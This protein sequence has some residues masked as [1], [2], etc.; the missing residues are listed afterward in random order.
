MYASLD[1]ITQAIDRLNLTHMAAYDGDGHTIDTAQTNTDTEL[2]D[3]VTELVNNHSGTIRLECWQAPP[4]RQ[5]G[6]RKADVPKVER[7]SWRVRGLLGSAVPPVATPERSEP[8][9]PAPA[10]PSLHQDVDRAIA[11][12]R[13]EWE[14]ERLKIEVKEL[15][16]LDDDDDD[17]DDREPERAAPALP[18]KLFGMTG[19]QTFQILQGL[20]NL[21]GRNGQQTIAGTGA[22]NGQPQLTAQELELFQAFRR[23]AQQRPDDAKATIET[24]MSQFGPN[25]APQPESNGQHG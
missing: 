4:V 14:F 13:M 3:L 9:R 22:N 23:F 25:A 16:A 6:Q 20:G 2:V 17:D 8:S 7:L 5:V 24:L 12:A 21:L 1:H 15:R 10:A 11:H 18:D 19:D